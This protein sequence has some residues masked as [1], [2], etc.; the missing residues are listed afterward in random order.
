MAGKYW[1]IRKNLEALAE[2]KDGA[3][4]SQVGKI[5]VEERQETAEYGK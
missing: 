4:M 5:K 1:N 3:G 2:F